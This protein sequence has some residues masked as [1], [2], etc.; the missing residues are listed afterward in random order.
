MTKEEVIAELDFLIEKC[1]DNEIT[2]IFI[3][4]IR[5]APERGKNMK[6]LE[7][8]TE[9]MTDDHLRHLSKGIRH[10]IEK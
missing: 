7:I 9:G 8:K 6:A 4:A 3:A 2:G 1:G 5:D 10:V